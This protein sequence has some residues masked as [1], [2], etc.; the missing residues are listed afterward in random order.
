[1]QL[2]DYDDVMSLYQNEHVRRFLGGTLTDVQF[3]PRF[4]KLCNQASEDEYYWVIRHSYD[5]AFMGLI[6]IDPHHDGDAFELSY[7]LLPQWWGSGYAEEVSRQI[8]HYA[9]TELGLPKIVAETQAANSASRRLLEKLGMKIIS[10]VERFGEQQYIYSISRDTMTEYYSLRAAEYEKIYNR[11]DPVRQAEQQSITDAM[12]QAF[13]DMT[14]LEIACGTGYWTERYADVTKHVTATDLTVE[15]LEI[16]IGKSIPN[17]DFQICDAYELSGVSNKQSEI[18]FNAACANFWFSHIPKARIREFLTGLHSKLS[19]GSVVFMADNIYVEGVG[20]SLV[21]HGGDSD[22]YK[23]RQLE[24]G[25][26]YEILKNYYSDNEL[27][28]IF[29]EY[30]DNLEIFMGECFWWVRYQVN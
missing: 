16:A 13:K 18:G 22:T 15:T 21:S 11:E 14:V 27:R 12:R 9:F 19:K 4:E 5:Q 6:S 8:L 23:L 26:S 3:R 30:A 10:T 17:T 25:T 1:M 20:G 2:T 28:E 24:N 7:Q 29:K